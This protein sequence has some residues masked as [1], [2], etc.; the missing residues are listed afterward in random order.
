MKTVAE[1]NAAALFARTIEQL[2]EPA[3]R[4]AA[5]DM[6]LEAGG[7]E[8]HADLLRDPMI[9]CLLAVETRLYPFCLGNRRGG[10]FDVLIGDEPLVVGYWRRDARGGTRRTPEATRRLRAKLLVL[11]NRR[12]LYFHYQRNPPKRRTTRA[13]MARFDVNN[14]FVYL[15]TPAERR[16]LGL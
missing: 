15:P 8:C 6:L 10:R 13:H 7:A 5:A 11:C 9:P 16:L 12:G 1:M 14:G 4:V 3:D 2:E